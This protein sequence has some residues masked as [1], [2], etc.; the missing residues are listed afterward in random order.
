MIWPK[1]SVGH[2]A[3]SNL[4]REANFHTNSKCMKQLRRSWDMAGVV[5]GTPCTSTDLGTLFNHVMLILGV[6]GHLL[7][8][9]N[10]AKSISDTNNF[11]GMT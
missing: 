11:A 1:P 7:G 8:K 6:G 2:A 9:V 5:R 4:G 10:S 3:L